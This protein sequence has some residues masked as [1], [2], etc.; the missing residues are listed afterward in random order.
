MPI[1]NL[2]KQKYPTPKNWNKIIIHILFYPQQKKV[3]LQMTFI[4][5]EIW[6]IIGIEE[7]SASW[8]SQ[9]IVCLNMTVWAFS[10]LPGVVSKDGKFFQDPL[11]NYSLN[12][13]K[14]MNQRQDIICW[15]FMRWGI[16]KQ[17]YTRYCS[18]WCFCYHWC[19]P[20]ASSKSFAAIVYYWLWLVN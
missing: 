1:L 2:F 10:N 5:Y 11:D 9:D 7:C 19:C 6:T 15:W 12:K 8:S 16:L 3:Y 17:V 20:S 18:S 14:M 4:V 13:R